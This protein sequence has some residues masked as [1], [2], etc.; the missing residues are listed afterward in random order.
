MKHFGDQNFEDFNFRWPTEEDIER[1][2]LVEPL[3]LKEIRT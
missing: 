3:K 1:L 2:D